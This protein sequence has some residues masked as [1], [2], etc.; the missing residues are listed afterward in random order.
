MQARPLRISLSQQL[1]LK[2]DD[3]CHCFAAS[4]SILP[5]NFELSE[6]CLASKVNRLG[7]Y[8]GLF[9]RYDELIKKKQIDAGILEEVPVETVSCTPGNVHYLPHHPVNQRDKQTTKVR[10]AS[11]QRL[12]EN[13]QNVYKLVFERRAFTFT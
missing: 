12:C 11:V 1:S 13:H 4:H 7:K 10:V 8:P 5:D 6:R 9:R 2:M 3:I